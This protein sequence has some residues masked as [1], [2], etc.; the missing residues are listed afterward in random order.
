MRRTQALVCDAGHIGNEIRRQSEE[1]F[2]VVPA[3]DGKSFRPSVSDN[4]DQ[5]SLR[6]PLL[7]LTHPVRSAMAHASAACS[8]CFVSSG[9][10]GLLLR[11]HEGQE[12]CTEGDHQP[13]YELTRVL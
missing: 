12:E 11:V 1:P 8:P 5:A 13:Q 3:G 6:V 2:V 4:S 7:V 9:E 10:G